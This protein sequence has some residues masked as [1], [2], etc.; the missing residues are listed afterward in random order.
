MKMARIS[1]RGVLALSK[2]S[3]RLRRRTAAHEGGWESGDARSKNLPTR[4]SLLMKKADRGSKI[5]SC[6]HMF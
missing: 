6:L 3:V 4:S 5:I 1:R 2:R